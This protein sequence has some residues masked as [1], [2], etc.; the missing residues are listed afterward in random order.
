MSPKL[1]ILYAIDGQ[2]MDQYLSE[3]MAQIIEY[4]LSIFHKRIEDIECDFE[5]ICTNIL[6]SN[7]VIMIL[8]KEFLNTIAFLSE[9]M[10]H[11]TR[12]L[13]PC[14]T[15]L[16]FF[17]CRESDMS[18]IHRSL[19]CGYRRFKRVVATQTHVKQFVINTIK[20]LQNILQLNEFNRIF[21]K[22]R[23][24]FSN[25]PQFELSLD[26]VYQVSLT[27]TQNKLI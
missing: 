1:F 19:L 5:S 22:R 10:F 3:E 2:E 14:K 18:C 23:T 16:M 6:Q 27:H 9:N 13:K 20:L 17:G 25:T 8:S 7:A 26:K 15:I 11:L 24:R 4:P 12:L 21:I